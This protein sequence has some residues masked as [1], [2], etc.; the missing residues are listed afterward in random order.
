MSDILYRSAFAVAADIKRGALT[1]SDV[2]AFFL[3]RVDRFTWGRCTG[4]R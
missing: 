1:S 3:D 4:C 2:L